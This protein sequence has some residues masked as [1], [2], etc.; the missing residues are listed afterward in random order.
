MILFTDFILKSEYL[1]VIGAKPFP[2]NQNVKY[3]C[4]HYA[5]NIFHIFR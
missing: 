3:E 2:A 5:F 1:F 4:F